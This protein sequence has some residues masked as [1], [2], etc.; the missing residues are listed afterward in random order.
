GDTVREAL[1][2]LHSRIRAT[3]VWPMIIGNGISWGNDRPLGLADFGAGLRVTFSEEMNAATATTSAFVVTLEV[4][5]DGNPALTVPQI[6]D[7]T[8]TAAGRDWTFVPHALDG[9]QVASWEKALGHGVRC[10]VRLIGDMILDQAGKRPL[11]GDTVGFVHT[12][13]YDTWVDL[14]LPSGDGQR[15]GDFESW[16]FLQGPQPLVQVESVSPGHGVKVAANEAP[17]AIMVSFTH[18][19]Q[20]STLTP[21][22]LQVRARTENQRG[23]GAPV[24]GKIQPYPFEANPQL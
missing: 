4:P 10:R 19:V 24:A 17:G 21:E 1:E 2:E 12:E 23:A 5:Q 11:D 22:S 16:F 7:G 3:P 15:G 18:P 13:G 14:K 20:F 9:G 8:V 6:I